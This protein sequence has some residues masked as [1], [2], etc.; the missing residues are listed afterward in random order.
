LSLAALWLAGAAWTL[1]F[2]LFALFY[3]AALTRPRV[4]ADVAG[5]I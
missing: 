4:P 2:G 5:T 1:A 3:G